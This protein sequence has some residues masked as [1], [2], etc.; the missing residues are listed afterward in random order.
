MAF[1]LASKPLATRTVAKRDVSAR[2][3]TIKPLPYAMDAF[4]PLLS[5]ESE[6]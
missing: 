5:K 2:A 6:W 1:S 3:V 4:A